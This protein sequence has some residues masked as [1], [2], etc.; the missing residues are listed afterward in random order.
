MQC[1]MARKAVICWSGGKDCAWALHEVRRLGSFEVV[2]AVTSLAAPA[3]NVAMHGVSRALIE[4]QLASA[5][6]KP[7]FAN[8]PWPCP[9][10]AYEAAMGT[11]FDEAKSLGASVCIFG[12]LF[13]RD[14]RSYREAQLAPLGLEA[15]FPL[16]G[17]DTAKLARTMIGAGL[18]A[19][20]A[21]ID[22]KALEPEF[23]GRRY[24]LQFLRDLPAGVDPCGEN[25]EFH[26]F[27]W[28]GPM[29]AKPID[30]MPGT[31]SMEEG[32][33]RVELK[34]GDRSDRC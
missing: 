11:A 27:V 9:N 34:P 26:S 32:F 12:D 19:H 22:L 14:I 21:C 33:A 31:L 15:S 8:L 30:V 1:L 29:L 7:I 6:L 3:G 2:A 28:D 25:G 18:E 23:A 5:G 16:W 10:P 20:I 24:D 13:L 4:A 17:V